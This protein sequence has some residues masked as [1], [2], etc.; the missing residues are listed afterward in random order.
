MAS[1]GLM[2]FPRIL[3]NDQLTLLGGLASGRY[4]PAWPFGAW[5]SVAFPNGATTAKHGCGGSTGLKIQVSFHPPPESRPPGT[6]LAA[7]KRPFTVVRP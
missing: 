4:T 5:R 6:G 2:F 7:R 3:M 1:A